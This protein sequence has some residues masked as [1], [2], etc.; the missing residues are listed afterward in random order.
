MGPSASRHLLPLLTAGWVTLASPASPLDSGAYT[1]PPSL[2]AVPAVEPGLVRHPVVGVLDDLGRL[3]VAEGPA[4]NLTR[5]ELLEKA[6]HSIRRLV[7]TD[8]DGVYDRTTVFADGLVY[9]RG[10][11]WVYDSLYVMSPPGLWY[12]EDADDDGVAE[13]RELLVAGFDFRPDSASLH[14]PFLHPDGRLYWSHGRAGHHVVDPAT[15]ALVSQGD[16]ALIWSCWIDGTDVRIHA[17]GAL[18]NPVELDFTETGEVLGAVNRFRTGPRTDALVHWLHGGFYPRGD[19]PQTPATRSGALPGP[20][21]AFGAAGLSGLCRYRSGKLGADWKDAWLAVETARNRISLT[22]LAPRG[23]SYRAAEPESVFELHRPGARLTDVI[24]D[25]NGDLLVIDAGGHYDPDGDAASD[26]ADVPGS[27]YRIKRAYVPHRAPAYRTIDEWG[28][29]D[30]SLVAQLLDSPDFFFRDRAMTE[31]AVRGH[32]AV[33]EI[34]EILRDPDAS[35]L[36]KRNGIWTLARM[37]F[38]D[39]PELMHEALANADP[40][41]RIAA[42]RALAVTRNWQ[43]IARH[44]PNEMVHEFDRNR[45]IARS[46]ARLVRGGDPTVARNAAMAIGA[47][48]EA[49]SIGSLLGRAGR[50]GHDPA[51]RHAITYALVEMADPDPVR[52]VLRS[53]NPKQQI[54]ALRALEAMPE[55]SPEALD[56]LPLLESPHPALRRTAVEV[57][58]EHPEWDA[59]VA[60]RFFRYAEDLTEARANLIL[61]LAPPFR[62][63]LPFLGFLDH[64]LTH[65][66]TDARAFALRLLTALPPETGEAVPPAWEPTL[67]EWLGNDETRP[68]AID[69]LRG[70]RPGPLGDDLRSVAADSGLDEAIRLRA[71]DAVHRKRD[72]L[73]DDLFAFLLDR[74]DRPEPSP[75]TLR[76]LSTANL[77]GAQRVALARSLDRAGPAALPRLLS[78]YRVLTREEATILSRTLPRSP[79]LAAVDRDRL[80][81]LFGRFDATIRG[82]IDAALR[83]QAGEVPPA[84]GPPVSPDSAESP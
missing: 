44:H 15:G 29:L 48:A 53:G 42:S 16:D 63:S 74:I 75:V 66:Q 8:G 40:T 73:P 26:R 47:M 9:P 4:E 61:E 71:L 17:G 20:L 31:L 52:A 50:V 67:R 36:A 54:V 19:R 23:A 39:G 25:R 59:A 28:R 21:H 13:T 65:E 60:N 83:P 81:Q 1:A 55:H 27:I 12:F 43:S 33:P 72:K 10:A 64:L 45:K 18:V 34:R 62:R 35:A 22:R 70:M 57:V 78:A 77:N 80:D 79:G 56:V 24:E 38:S 76:V 69:L 51:L 46:L 30:P 49:S 7:D 3:Y 41:V 11:L 32:S 14:G 58:R 37:R 68:A 2:E 84:A 5:E 82:P 6:P